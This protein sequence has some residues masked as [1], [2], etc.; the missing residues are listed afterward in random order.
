MQAH[1]VIGKSTTRVDV[2]EKA[3][4]EAQYTGDIIL[5]KM[6]YGNILH[7]PYA[8]A[9]ILNI[10]TG[11]AKK[12]PGI[13]AVATGKDITDKP[14]GLIRT[15]PAPLFLRDKFALAKDKVRFIGDEVAAVAAVDM[16][17]AEEALE[18]IKVEYEELPA[19]FDPLEAMK[20]GAPIIHESYPGGNISTDGH[21]NHG[22]VEKGFKE[23]DFVF[24]EHFE[25]QYVCHSP[26]EPH[27]AVANYL[28][29]GELTIWLSTQ[30]PFYD[31]TG[32]AEALG[33]PVTKV[34]VIKPHVGGAFGGKTDTLP[35]YPIAA[36]LSKMTGRPVKVVHTREEELVCT[37]R[38]HPIYI[39][40]KIGLKKDGKI[41]AMESRAILDG[42]AYFSFGPVTTVIFGGFQNGPYEI[43][44]FRYDGLRICTNKPFCG[45]M[46]GHGAIQ[47]KFAMESIIDIAASKMGIDQLEIR[48]INAIKPGVV[49]A[50]GFIVNSTGHEEC[51]QKTQEKL[52]WK[53]KWG[54]HS[55]T[56]VGIAANFFL[57]GAAINF[58]FDHHPS[59]S[60]VIIEANEDGKF[61]LKTGTSDLGQGSMTTL[62]MIAAETIGVTLDDIRV[63]AAD[64]ITTPIDM[65]SY[66]SRVTMFGG[67][68]SLNA[69]QE[70]RKT[71]FEIAADT[72]EANPEDLEAK[73]GQIFVKGSPD[74]SVSHAETINLYFEKN[75]QPL[76]VKGHY[77]P[78]PNPHSPDIQIQGMNID[79]VNASPA[80]SFGAQAVELDVDKETGIVKVKKIIAAHD[81]GTAINPQAVEGQIE[82][83][84]SMS[85]GQAL[86]EDFK[87]DKCWPMTSSFLD[88]K[89]PTSMDHPEIESMLVQTMDVNGPYGAK[90]VGE[91]VNIPTIP[92]I[93]NAIYDAVG[94]RIKDLPV[95]PEKILNGLG[96]KI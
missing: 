89:L 11:K 71:L 85:L 28:Q 67:N 34:R 27:S 74:K 48:I 91:G 12:L 75:I 82:G 8:H 38:R 68:A 64:T 86:T 70:M 92:A 21:F 36:L 30:T 6:L 78:P 60:A 20:P 90:E 63:I 62:A 33:I 52:R 66:S 79:A 19:V 1:S 96:E 13:K 49:T 16:D 93:T 47:A 72:L 4:G 10:D 45:A 40:Q 29:S 84:V 23:S 35:P 53:D 88:Y 65:G 22:D 43:P 26:L 9:R 80:Y 5:P 46:R 14:H 41:V 55:G 17:T 94:V 59:H 3:V 32:I 44:N 31:Q 39:D 81:C 37:S 77:N 61:T 95:T 76:I 24:E 15:P 57:S 58:F 73:E 42:G 7:S 18:L 50:G 51:I 54:K 69:A 87:M 56:G 25:T 83:G 2:K